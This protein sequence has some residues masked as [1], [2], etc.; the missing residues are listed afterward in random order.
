MFEDF[1]GDY[2]N[3][4]P[5][6]F[7]QRGLGS[8]VIIDKDGYILTNEHV[9]ADADKITVTLSDGRSFSGEIKGKD[10][11]M[12]L[13]I[14]KINAQNLPAA[15]L[16]DSGQV[17]V[18]QWAIA[19]GNPFGYALRG[20]EPT[21]TVGVIS[22]LHRAMPQTGWRDRS[23]DDLIQTDAAINPGNSGGPLVNINGEVVGINV[24]I[25]STYG[26]YM[27][28]GFAIPVNTATRILDNLRTGKKVLYGWLGVQV[29]DMS[30]DL[31]KSLG[32]A[33]NQGALVSG[34]L[35]AGPA[36][37]AGLKQGDVIR[38]FAGE[39]INNVRELLKAVG[40]AQVGKKAEVE[41]LRNKKI[42]KVQVV[43]GER[44]EQVDQIQKS[45]LIR[46]AV[47]SWRGLEV[48]EITP[49][50]EEKFALQKGESGVMISNVEPGSPADN[51]GLNP[52]DIIDEIDRQPIKNLQDYKKAIAK[53]KGDCLLHTQNGYSILK[54]E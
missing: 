54:E 30:E 29:Q 14:I 26:G 53:A 12:D 39:K 23:Y 32:L 49:Q 13:A 45:G 52:G 15:K 16:G 19:I 42:E 46:P 31:A 10:S 1:F 40:E 38:S 20:S 33:D 35:S 44:P 28:L 21:V 27:G 48:G 50:L 17:K 47:K 8:G 5:S 6:E 34:V 7:K 24:A 25:I 11:R 41:V 22:A 43:V 9:V 51:V 36:E 2:F 18:G 4:F 37:K 3:N